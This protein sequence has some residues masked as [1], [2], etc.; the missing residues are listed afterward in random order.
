MINISIIIPNL[1]GGNFLPSCL[2]GLFE[3][4]TNDTNLHFEIIMVDNGSTDNSKEIFKFFCK[5]KNLNHKLIALTSN[6]GF[7]QAVNK[8]IENAG[9]QYVC[10]LNNDIILHQKWF[11]LISKAILSN[12][13]KN[14][15]V[16]CGTVLNIDGTKYESQGLKFEYRGK[17]SNISNGKNFS[18][19]DIASLKP[20]LIWGSS[21]AAVIYQKDLIDKIGL[22]DKD[23]FAYE[24]DVDLALR[25][26]KLNFHT[27]YIPQ[28]VSYH[29][30]GGTS[31]KMGNFRNIH[32]AKNWIYIIIKNYSTTELKNNF[33]PLLEER[34][35]NLS[36]L[37]KSTISIYKL[38]ALYQ[39]PISIAKAYVP[40]LINLPVLL[41]KRRQFQNLLK[42]I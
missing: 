20:T 42:S 33:F 36:G 4:A 34:L 32:D 6:S 30:G 41:K 10:L 17:C 7:A 18:S 22:F 3:S 9:F 37:I 40:V 21:A 15:A 27:L 28:A 31:N 38:K 25:L 14:T 24:E 29:F 5:S 16:F 2:Q 26:H 39:L 8:G 13:D 23:F 35:R 12:K 19:N 1:N 11:S